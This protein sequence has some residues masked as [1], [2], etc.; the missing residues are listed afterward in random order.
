MG[1]LCSACLFSLLC[2]GLSGSE[3]QV[4]RLPI[5]SKLLMTLTGIDP[6][7]SLQ[8]HTFSFKNLLFSSSNDQPVPCETEA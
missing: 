7:A 8:E 4:C 6:L 1:S 3:M 5:V 2:T